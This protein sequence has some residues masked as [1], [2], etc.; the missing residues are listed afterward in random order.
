MPSLSFTSTPRTRVLVG[1]WR[2]DEIEAYIQT[3]MQIDTRVIDAVK[4]SADYA[5]ARSHVA[6]LGSRS[7]STV[8]ALGDH[9]HL[10]ALQAEALF[11]EF[12]SPGG[13]VELVKIDLRKLVAVQPRVEWSHVEHLMD[14][15]P[16]PGDTD[17]LLKFC[18]PLQRD[19]PP[20][21]IQPAF[22]QTTQTL[23]F[24]TDNPDFRVCGPVVE[25]IGN[26]R[27]VLGFA[28]GPGLQ[29]MSVMKF[30]GRYLLKNGHHRAVALAA[31]G[32]IDAPVLLLHGT[33]IEH[34]PVVRPGRFS[35]SLVLGEAPPRVEDFL[36]PAAIDLP[37]R[38]TRTLYS[39]QAAS[40]VIVD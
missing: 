7:E 1:F 26:G 18:V 27:A 22:A 21:S 37:R 5:A 38:R 32:H 34:T 15:A 12:A 33:Q 23:A 29:Q 40:H 19:A 9:A 10:S 24:V 20:A 11:Q 25:S 4:L 39:F 14:E 13:P 30:E 8:T 16:E 35:P 31:R 17:G 28:I 6:G 2:P 36:S 3:T